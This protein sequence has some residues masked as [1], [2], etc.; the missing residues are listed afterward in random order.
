M[1]RVVL[2]EDSIV[3]TSIRLIEESGS[4]RFTLRRLGEAL[5]ADPTAIYRH[6]KDKDELLRAVGDR[7]IAAITV[8]LPGKGAD[9]RS[10]VTEVCVRLRAAHV[11]Q[12]HLAALVRSA[13]PMHENEFALT[14]LLLGQ[15]QLA[16]LD[17]AGV[18]L[19]YHALIELTV[20]SAALDAA[21]AALAPEHRSERYA[22]WR[23]AYASLDE[24]SHP[25]SIAIA[26]FLYVRSA[27]ERFRYALDRLLDGIAMRMPDVV[28][29]GTDP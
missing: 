23:R 12:P 25:A 10:I 20:G 22:S 13:P 15:L 16:G 17:A 24:G 8:G 9:W 27:E 7:F 3:E 18:A 4:D 14:E 1:T 6:F 21:T 2:T 28:V 26:P 29:T 19:A 5:G 11:A